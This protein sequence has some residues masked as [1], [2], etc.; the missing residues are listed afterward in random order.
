MQQ[1]HVYIG[2]TWAAMPTYVRV[3]I[4]TQQEMDRFKAAYKKAYETAPLPAS[5]FL[6]LPF[7]EAPSE[8]NRHRYA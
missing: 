5:A 1:D 6:D 4:G 2:R 8:L 3:T 7:H